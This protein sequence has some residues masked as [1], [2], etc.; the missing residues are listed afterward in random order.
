[1]HGPGS[2]LVVLAHQLERDRRSWDTIVP[3]LLEEG[4]AVLAL[5]L[6]SFGAS[7]KEAASP[8]A[9]SAVDRESLHLD[10]LAAIPA[11]GRCGGVDTSRVAIVAAGLSVNPAVRC[12]LEQPSVRA[13]AL[14]SGSVRGQEEDFLVEH[15]DFPVLMVASALDSPGAY[16]MGFLGGRL[17]GDDQLY[18]ELQPDDEEDAVAWRGTDGLREDVGL[19]DLLVWFLRRTF[20]ARPD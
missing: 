20:P 3:L 18:F 4:Y 14:L 17:T 13:L 8:A 10:L 15:T 9:L 11:A 5:D 1:V 16:A 19:A 6:R 12:A 2:P 7:T